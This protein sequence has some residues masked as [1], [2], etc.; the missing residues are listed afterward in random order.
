MSGWNMLKVMGDDPTYPSIP[1]II[2]TASALHEQADIGNYTKVVRRLPKPVALNE[3]MQ[4]IEHVVEPE[5]GK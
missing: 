4:V 3:L 1:V 5:T 2:M